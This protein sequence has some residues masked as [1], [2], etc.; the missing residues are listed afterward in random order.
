MPRPADDSVEDE[1][2]TPTPKRAPGGAKPQAVLQEVSLPE[3][4]LRAGLPIIRARV[5]YLGPGEHHAVSF[6][7]QI[8]EE[9]LEDPDGPVRR[10][11]R[12]GVERRYT[13]LKKAVEDAGIT[14][15]D[16][17]VRDTLGHL[18]PQRMMPDTT[19]PSRL[20][21]RPFAWSEHVGHLRKFVLAKDERGEHLYHVMV[22]PEHVLL[23]QDH[24]R[25]TERGRK[26]QEELLSYVASR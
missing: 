23:L 11:D 3:E 7:G 1:I 4:T 12:Q 2:P 8:H 16:F 15:Y 14:Q 18:I 25:R 17:T 22:R 20:R 19:E 24:I 26:Q 21:G 10:P 6:V 9:Y 5:V 13:V